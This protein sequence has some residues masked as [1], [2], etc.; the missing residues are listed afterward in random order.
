MQPT[1]SITFPSPCGLESEPS[2]VQE[3][4]LRK[5]L[6]GTTSILITTPRI[7]GSCSD[8]WTMETG[9]AVS[10]SCYFR[11]LVSSS[12]LVSQY[13]L[14]ET[15]VHVCFSTAL[16]FIV[17]ANQINAKLYIEFEVLSSPYTKVIQ[18]FISARFSGPESVN[19]HYSMAFCVLIIKMELGY[20][21][22][23][24]G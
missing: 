24:C 15:L 22:M 11:F 4:P 10:F 14:T 21:E 5:N 1:F 2:S 12:F 19:A 18:L 3:S 16:I 23:F 13:M 17:M 7:P 20:S 9:Q 6:I 8:I